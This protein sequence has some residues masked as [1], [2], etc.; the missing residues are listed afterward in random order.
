MI[1]TSFVCFK[2]QFLSANHDKE[3]IKTMEE[4]TCPLELQKPLC[5]IAKQHGILPDASNQYVV[6]IL[7]YQGSGFEFPN[8]NPHNS[9]PSPP[10]PSPREK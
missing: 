2:S 3:I 10:T 5:F 1:Q 9:P 7:H 6:G 4:L 8:P